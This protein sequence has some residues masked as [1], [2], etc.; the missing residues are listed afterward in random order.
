MLHINFSQDSVSIIGQDDSSHWVEEHFE[1][2]L[3]SKCSSD[4][5]SYRFGSLDVG[6]LGLLAL[7]SLGILVED[8]N[9]RLTH[10]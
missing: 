1:H 10:V 7:I 3:G 4:D 9:W 6:F 5:V 2:A 8:V